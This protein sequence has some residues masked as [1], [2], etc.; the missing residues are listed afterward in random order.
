[1]KKEQKN[2]CYVQQHQFERLLH[3]LG[4]GSITSLTLELRNM[5]LR[6]MKEQDSDLTIKVRR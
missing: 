5:L 1:M 2:I 6:K 3:E 4:E